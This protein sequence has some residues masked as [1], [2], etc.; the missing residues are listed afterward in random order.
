MELE[1]AE[2]S[3]LAEPNHQPRGLL[4]GRQVP[5]YLV[6]PHVVLG[7]DKALLDLAETFLNLVDLS[8]LIIVGEV[9]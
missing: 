9:D 7:Q 8:L 3:V 5:G 1:V 2:V 4:K 6:V